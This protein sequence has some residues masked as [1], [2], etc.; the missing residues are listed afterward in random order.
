MRIGTLTVGRKVA[1][2][3]LIFFVCEV[4]HGHRLLSRKWYFSNY[5]S[6][7]DAIF[8]AA[9]AELR[10]KRSGKKVILKNASPVP[11][12]GVNVEAPS[13][14]D[15]RIKMNV[16]APTEVSWLNQTTD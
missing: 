12:I 10:V 5:E 16:A 6:A 9:P 4:C 11:A 3:G 14:S 13:V 2:S 15:R 8:S 1:D 7:P